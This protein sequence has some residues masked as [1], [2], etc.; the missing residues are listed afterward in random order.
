M[1]TTDRK[2][3]CWWRHRRALILLVLCISR[4]ELQWIQS[5]KATTVLLRCPCAFGCK[6]I[7]WLCHCSYGHKL[8]HYTTLHNREV[9]LPICFVETGEENPRQ[10]P[11]IHSRRGQN[12]VSTTKR[13][14]KLDRSCWIS[15]KLLCAC[16]HSSQLRNRNIELKI[17]SSLV[18]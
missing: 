14:A 16:I 6:K 10:R 17:V 3:I 1:K 9:G 5:I 12:E 18:Q 2:W 11:R 7:V 15:S 13:L 8:T 4:M